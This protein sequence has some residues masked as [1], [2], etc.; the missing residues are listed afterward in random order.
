MTTDD[1]L[2]LIL[3]TAEEKMDKAITTLH[4]EMGSI[5]T[6]RANP[7]LLD[8]VQV[9]YYGQATPVRQMA[10][11]SVQEGQTL[12]VQP[13]EKSMLTEIEKAIAIS[14]I[15]LPVNNDGT[16]IRMTVPPLTEERRK[17]FAKLARKYG[18]EGKV[19]IRNIRRDASSEADK[20]KKEDNLPEDVLKDTQDDI[21]KLTDRFIHKIEQLVKEKENEV[22]SV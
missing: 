14:G 16:V 17:E 12:V 8:R 1:N 22:L 15:D 4:H 7:L 9:D 6:G 19:T 10:N 3:L 2:A 11:V 20:A 21:Q 13:Y 18:E 5:R